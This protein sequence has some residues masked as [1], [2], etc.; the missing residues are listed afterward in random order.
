MN[1]TSHRSMIKTLRPGDDEFRLNDGIITCPRAGFEVDN[2]C[3]DQYR[4]IL[5]ECIYRGWLKPVAHVYNR[6][7]MWDRLS[8]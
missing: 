6:E 3:P 1:L 7:V 8:K 5:Q 4:L 2:E